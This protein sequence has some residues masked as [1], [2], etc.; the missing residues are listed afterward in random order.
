MFSLLHNSLFKALFFMDKRLTLQWLFNIVFV[1]DYTNSPKH[2]LSPKEDNRKYTNED[3]D[4]LKYLHLQFI[5]L[6]MYVFNSHRVMYTLGRPQYVKICFFIYCLGFVILVFGS[7]TCS[8]HLHVFC[9][10]ISFSFLSLLVLFLP[11]P[12]S[13][14]PSCHNANCVH[15]VPPPWSKF[16][17][18]SFLPHQTV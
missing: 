12:P 14:V 11:C 2:W 18:V 3:A 13:P 9:C 4:Q 10:T 15:Y 7:V 1:K 8:Y 6:L 16:Q 17:Q 5:Y